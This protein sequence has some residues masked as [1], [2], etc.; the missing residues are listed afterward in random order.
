MFSTALIKSKLEY[1]ETVYTYTQTRPRKQAVAINELAEPQEQ[2]IA[3][4][5]HTDRRMRTHSHTY[6]HTLTYTHTHI[7][8]HTHTQ[9]H[10]RTQRYIRTQAHIGVPP[11]TSV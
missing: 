4:L 3:K 8:T 5:T 2:G 6:T 11:N 9:T 1:H 7:H 10:T